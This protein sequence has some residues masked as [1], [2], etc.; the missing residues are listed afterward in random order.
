[1]DMIEAAVNERD[2]AIIAVGYEAGLRIGEPV[3][4]TWGNVIW[5]EWG[6]KIKVHGKTSGRVISIIMVGFSFVFF[7]FQNFQARPVFSM[8]PAEELA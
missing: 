7:L 6:A 5:T 8:K 3:S 1:M 4:L 2:R